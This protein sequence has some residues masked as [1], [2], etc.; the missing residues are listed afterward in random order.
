MGKPD[1]EPLGQER[2]WL[3]VEATG[4]GVGRWKYT[5][6]RSPPIPV[7]R[8]CHREGR[9]HWK[10]E[11]RVWAWGLHRAASRAQSWADG[12][13]RGACAKQPAQGWSVASTP[14]FPRQPSMQPKQGG[15]GG[16]RPP[17]GRGHESHPSPSTGRRLSQRQIW[18]H[19]PT[20]SNFSVSPSA[21]C[22]S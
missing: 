14:P 3:P 12:G 4:R 17:P 15:S 10:T 19:L 2:G 7:S 1:R 21:H 8:W 20:G 22:P 9:P 16:D 11:G 5:W 18:R 6:P 13:T